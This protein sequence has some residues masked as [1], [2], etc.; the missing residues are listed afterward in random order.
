VTV[1]EP[2]GPMGN[3]V[4][5]GAYSN[6][7]S[8]LAGIRHTV[9]AGAWPTRGLAERAGVLV[10]NGAM[11]S[12]LLRCADGRYL[13]AARFWLQVA[14][15]LDDDAHIYQHVAALR[16]ATQCADTG[17]NASFARNCM[18]RAAAAE[19]QCRIDPKPGPAVVS[20]P[21]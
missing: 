13:R 4:T 12:L 18:K 19:C 9:A 15:Y 21:D 16:L 11:S 3:G 17:G 14:S 1:S 7:I 5:S 6:I 2:V 20:R 8:T 10:T